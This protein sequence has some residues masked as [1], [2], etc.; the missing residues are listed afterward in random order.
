[1]FSW[2]V[3]NPA[4]TRQD[5]R[6]LAWDGSNF[7]L[8]ARPV[9]ASSGRVLFKYD[10]AGTGTPSI[11]ILTP[12]IN[13]GDVQVNTTVTSEVGIKNYGTAD[14]IITSATTAVNVFSVDE[15][16][17]ITIKP[18]STKSLTVKFTPV[19]YQMYSDSVKFYHN[20]P[21]FAYSKTFVTGHGVYT[22]PFAGLS[23]TSIN[24]GSRR[25]N[26]TSY[27]EL[28]ITNFGTNVLEIDSISLA[29]G[30]FFYLQNVSAPVN[31]N[32]NESTTF[33][34]WFNPEQ[35]LTYND[36]IKIY[37]NASNGSLITVPLTGTGVTL[38]P[39]LGTIMWQGQ[40]PDNPNTVR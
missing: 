2:H 38:N 33:R 7:W 39:A 27:Q 11:Q 34:I 21:N 29:T 14:L 23:Q 6:G 9:G 20:D 17:P 32:L 24:Y 37:S 30:Q 1:M 16:F 35:L 13:F 31:L 26:S 12:S 4:G 22:A 10:L 25:V 36:N 8:L 3:P 19:S 18:D 40:I 15:T 28:T 5:P